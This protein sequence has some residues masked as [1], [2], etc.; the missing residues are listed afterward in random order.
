MLFRSLSTRLTLAQYTLL[1]G[2]PNGPRDAATVW[3]GRYE[4]VALGL[5]RGK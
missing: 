5:P 2:D 4:P 3:T 1:Y